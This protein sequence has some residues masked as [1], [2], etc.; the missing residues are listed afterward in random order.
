MKEKTKKKKISKNNLMTDK[1]STDVIS[2]CR[3]FQILRNAKVDLHFAFIQNK[4]MSAMKS[5]FRELYSDNPEKYLF[6]CCCFF[7]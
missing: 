2:L 4:K 3:I 1:I 6:C 5:K 7:F